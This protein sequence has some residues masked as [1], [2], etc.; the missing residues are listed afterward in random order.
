MINHEPKEITR[1]KEAIRAQHGCESHYLRTIRVDETF[2]SVTPWH[3]L[4]CIFAIRWTSRSKVLL[5]LARWLRRPRLRC[6]ADSICLF[7][8]FRGP[9]GHRGY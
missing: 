2:D 5:R 3:H 7:A 1:L 9:I 4:V 6:F 8:G